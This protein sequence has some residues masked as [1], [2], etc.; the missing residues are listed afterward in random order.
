M[1][2]ASQFTTA[3]GL[4]ES[5][6]NPNAPLGDDGRAVGRF[7]AHPDWQWTWAKHYNLAPN[8]DEKWDS[9]IERLVMAFA[10]DHLK[11]MTPEKVAMY[12]HL[13]HMSAPI[14]KGWDADYAARFN[15]RLATVQA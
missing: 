11:Y 12:F 9:W 1:I 7:Q 10:A 3:L 8:L 4:T 13:G 14:D 2:S 5:D 15:A 6:G